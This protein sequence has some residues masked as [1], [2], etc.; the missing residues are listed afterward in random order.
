M[1]GKLLKHDLDGM[2]KFLNVFYILAIFFAVLTRMFFSIEDSLI[3]NI[4]AQICS[5]ATIAMLFNI[6]MNNII[7]GWVRFKQ[8]IYGDES[9]L[10][11]TLPVKKQTVYSSKIIS[12][13]VTLL[14]S[15]LVILLTLFI[16][17]YS[18]ENIQTLKQMLL[19][20]VEMYDST[21]I[22]VIAPILFVLFLEILNAI[23]SGIIGIIV[24]H[25]MNNSKTGLSILFGFITYMATQ[26]II[27]AMMFCFAIF[28]KE[29]M[30]LFYTT[31]LVDITALKSV[32]NMSI[33]L[34]MSTLVV[35]YF[36]G[37]KLFKKGVDV[38]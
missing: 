30:N 19:P 23:F 4:I 32:M 13:I 29:I 2:F 1:L 26:F 37:L 36:V 33:I 14:A 11:H 28:N 15:M 27:L 7:R 9:Y 35:G 18:K 6:L 21:F 8:N 20:L 31:E 24:G 5:S 25:K 38:E 16:A 10:T 12:A 3:M 17:Y 22:G 34:Y